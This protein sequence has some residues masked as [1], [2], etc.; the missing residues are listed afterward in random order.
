MNFI[1]SGKER[2]GSLEILRLI[3]IAMLF[4]ALADNPF[5][6]YQIL[7]WLVCIVAGTLALQAYKQKNV[8][9][10]WMLAIM[11]VLFNPIDPTVLSREV[12]Q[13]IDV[14]CGILLAGS[15]HGLNKKG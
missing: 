2:L 12:W 11:V 14:I 10:A 8:L 9:W 7:R 4:W 3:T 13:A 6:Y 1:H 5:V 15:M